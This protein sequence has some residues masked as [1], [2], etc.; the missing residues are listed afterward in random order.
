MSPILCYSQSPRDIT[1]TNSDITAQ[2]TIDNNPLKKNT[3]GCIKFFS[4]IGFSPYL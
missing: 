3:R 1:I 4:F 2:L